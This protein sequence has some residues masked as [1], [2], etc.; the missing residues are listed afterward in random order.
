MKKDTFI[1]LVQNPAV[2]NASVVGSLEQLVEEYSYFQSGRILLTKALYN[3]NDIRF[4]ATLKRTA[5]CIADRSRLFEVIHSSGEIIAESQEISEQGTTNSEQQIEEREEPREENIV[6]E[7]LSLGK[8]VPERSEG[9][10]LNI[11]KI[12]E[13]EKPE[14]EEIPAKEEVPDPFEHAAE[15][16]IAKEKEEVRVE[17]IVEDT[18]SPDFDYADLIKGQESG[19]R[20]Q[21]ENSKEPRAERVSEQVTTNSEQLL[22]QSQEPRAEREKYNEPEKE[23]ATDNRE[24]A[25]E[26]ATNLLS[27]SFSGWLKKVKGEESDNSEQVT[28]NSEQF[29]KQELASGNLELATEKELKTKNDLIDRFM[30]AETKIV[31]QKAEFYSP[32]NMAKKSVVDE[33]D[34]V[35]ETLAKVYAAQ[36]NNAKAIRIYQKLSLVNTEKSTYFAAQIELLKQK[37]S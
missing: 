1:Q 22:A 16:A 24:P 4:D 15:K 14:V 36:G 21:A 13:Q 7:K 2:A 11:D 37:E 17:D 20:G 34:I 19:V 30:T 3:E 29:N 27:L 25:T 8:G 28:V 35:S 6:D 26:P 9:E 18:F 5:A 23:L 32:I 33:E 31:P 12:P 10:G